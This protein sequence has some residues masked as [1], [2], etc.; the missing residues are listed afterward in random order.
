MDLAGER[1]KLR[2]MNVISV[3]VVPLRTVSSDLK[4]D[5]KNWKSKNR[6]HLNNSIEIDHNSLKI[7]GD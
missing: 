6:N 1:R 4:E 5:W 2:K 7:L 3:V